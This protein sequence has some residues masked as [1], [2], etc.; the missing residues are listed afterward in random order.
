MRTP[1]AGNETCGSKGV[2]ALCHL[3]LGGTGV[4]L[5]WVKMVYNEA[6]CKWS[7]TLS[8]E[9]VCDNGEN[10]NRDIN[11]APSAG[12]A[13]GRICMATSESPGFFGASAVLN[14]QGL[15]ASLGQW[16]GCWSCVSVMYC[17]L[18]SR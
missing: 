11:T 1:K 10:V 8:F 17:N 9:I 16:C 5:V 15:S 2:S 14:I 7:N 4:A 12:Q 6:K 18:E 3:I 13:W